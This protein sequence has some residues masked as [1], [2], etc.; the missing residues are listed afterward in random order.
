MISH[1]SLVN[2]KLGFARAILSSIELG[3]NGGGKQA[4]L[5]QAQCE[6]ALIHL[7]NAYHFYLRELAESNGVKHPA[8]VSSLKTLIEA[9]AELEKHPNEAAELENLSA[10]TGSWLNR[11]RAGYESIYK[12]PPTAPKQKSF[13]SDNLINVV[14]VALEPDEKPDFD[15]LKS[16]LDEFTALILRQRQTSAEY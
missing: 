10:K 7:Y 9:L 5:R 2:Q 6:A 12:S 15:S 1:L 8:T 13:R 3:V 4:L 11:M 16:W 14:D